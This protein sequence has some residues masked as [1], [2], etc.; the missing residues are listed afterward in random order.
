MV[1]RLAEPDA[2]ID[3]D[4]A[5]RDTSRDRGFHARPQVRTD[6]RDHVVVARVVL[7][8][9]RRAAHV[10]RDEPGTGR[11]NHV[12]DVGIGDARPIRR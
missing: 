10:H 2:G 8:R 12:E 4:R 1:D 7:H 6:F 9:L 3:E 5:A 11:G